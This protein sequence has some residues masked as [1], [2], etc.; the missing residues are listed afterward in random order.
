MLREGLLQ[1][2]S[3]AVCLTHRIPILG[4]QLRL[5]AIAP[6]GSTND[7]LLYL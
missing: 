5:L 3:M 1:G 2:H 6:L 7:A 4:W